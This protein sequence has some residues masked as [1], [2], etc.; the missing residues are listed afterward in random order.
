MEKVVRDSLLQLKNIECWALKSI[1]YYDDFKVFIPRIQG[2]LILSMEYASVFQQTFAQIQ[3]LTK[4]MLLYKP[5]S[6]PKVSYTST[7]L[8]SHP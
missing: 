6:L 4:F 2:N 5:V 1:M 8:P 7:I 3:L